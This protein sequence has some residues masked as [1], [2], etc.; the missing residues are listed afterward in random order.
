MFQPRQCYTSVN[1]QDSNTIEMDTLNWKSQAQ[2]ELKIAE[3]ARQSGNE[4]KARVCAR[5]AAGHIAGEYLLRRGFAVNSTSAYTRL[6]HLDNM[7]H[8]DARIHEVVRS[9]LIHVNQDHELPSEI[10]LLNEARW[11]AQ[12]LLQENL[13]EGDFHREVGDN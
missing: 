4:G 9:F 13:S 2:L 3:S 11:L 8:L 5:R 1:Q 12:I 10:D 6:Q 7:P